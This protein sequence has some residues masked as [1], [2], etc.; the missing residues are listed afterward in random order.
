MCQLYSFQGSF[1]HIR[2]IDDLII[3]EVHIQSGCNLTDLCLITYQDCI[4]NA[5]SLGLMYSFQ[6]CTVLCNGDCDGLLPTLFYFC[7][8]VIKIHFLPFL[9]A[10]RGLQV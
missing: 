5:Q 2:L 10:P 8:D 7:Y 6:Y 4:C 3:G 1:D 9:S